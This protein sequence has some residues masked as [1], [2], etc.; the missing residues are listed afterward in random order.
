MGTTNQHNLQGLNATLEL[1]KDGNRIVSGSGKVSA[2]QADGTT[3]I[4]VEIADATASTHAVTQAQLDVVAGKS[5]GYLAYSYDAS[6]NISQLSGQG[7][8]DSG[9]IRH[10]DTY[11]IGVAG[12]F[13]GEAAEVGDFIVAL[14]A[15]PDI[16]DNTAT[17]TDWLHDE[18]RTA[19]DLADGTTLD[20]A[21]GKL[22]IK[23]AGVSTDK[24]AAA[25]VT[26]DK[27]NASAVTE[28][29][30]NNLA[31]TDAK[32]AAAAVTTDKIAATAV[33][34]AK[35]ANGV[36]AKLANSEALHDTNVPNIETAIGGSFDS[37][38][39]G[40]IAAQTNYLTT[41]TIVG[42]LSQAD[43]TLKLHHTDNAG[44]TLTAA[45]DAGTQNVGDAIKSGRVLTTIMVTPTT[46]A[47]GSGCTMTIGVSGDTD[48]YAAAS[49]I[50]LY[51]SGVSIVNVNKPLSA[52]E[53][54]IAT[55]T[56][57]TATQGTFQVTVLHV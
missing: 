6:G 13:L 36:T 22:L 46:T 32:L 45:H 50:D 14:V 31:V 20:S 18:R 19:S 28:A 44:R 41:T 40:L 34:E 24:I 37:D 27:I 53:Q 48:K 1:G 56:Q 25:A 29:K 33:T 35:L 15:N 49:A 47:N 43:S 9:A 10:G 17:N 16:S 39:E 30:I 5:G 2:T 26:A 52:D 57:G 23:D 51:D 8:G 55:V 4:N 11:K 54:I 7:S 42:Q 3:L 12:T 21:A 38:N